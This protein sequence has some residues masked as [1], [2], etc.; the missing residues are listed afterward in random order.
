MPDNEAIGKVVWTW[1]FWE[2]QN[3]F[4]TG[5]SEMGPGNGRWNIW[6]GAGRWNGG[7]WAGREEPGIASVLSPH[8]GGLAASWRHAGL[9]SSWWRRLGGPRECGTYW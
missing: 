6:R 7:V 2:C 8:E 3:D 1:L 4:R 5:V 9:A